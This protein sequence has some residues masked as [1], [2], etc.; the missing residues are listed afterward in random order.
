MG[1]LEKVGPK[2]ERPAGGFKSSRE[3][4]EGSGRPAAVGAKWGTGFKRVKKRGAL[5]D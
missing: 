5:E 3:I 4:E 1:D 2:G